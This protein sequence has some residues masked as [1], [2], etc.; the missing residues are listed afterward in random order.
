MKSVFNLEDKVRQEMVSKNNK[1]KFNAIPRTI[2]DGLE[3]DDNK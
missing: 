1:K 2:F 3:R